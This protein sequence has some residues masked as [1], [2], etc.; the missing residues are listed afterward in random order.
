MTTRYDPVRRQLNF[1]DLSPTDSGYDD[2]DR[3]RKERERH[4]KERRD[5]K[6]EGKERSRDGGDPLTDLNWARPSRSEYKKYDAD[7]HRGSRTERSHRESREGSYSHASRRDS[8]VD[9][10]RASKDSDLYDRRRSSTWSTADTM[11]EDHARRA[12]SGSAYIGR[13]S[14]DDLKRPDDIFK[15]GSKLTRD[16]LKR[17]DK[18]AADKPVF[19]KPEADDADTDHD[20]GRSTSADADA[21]PTEQEEKGGEKKV[22]RR[23]Y[24]QHL[25]N[26]IE[27]LQQEVSDRQTQ[28]DEPEP[29]ISTSTAPTESG[30][31]STSNSTPTEETD[32]SSDEDRDKRLREKA[33]RGSGVKLAPVLSDCLSI[34]PVGPVQNSEPVSR[35]DKGSLGKVVCVTP[36]R[37]VDLPD[38]TYSDAIPETFRVWAAGSLERSELVDDVTNEIR[39][40]MQGKTSGRQVSAVVVDSGCCSVRNGALLGDPLRAVVGGVSYDTAR[41]VFAEVF[42]RGWRD[43]LVWAFAIIGVELLE[44]IEDVSHESISLAYRRKCL[45]AHP[46][47]G[48]NNQAYFKLQIAIDIIRAACEKLP[49]EGPVRPTI[50]DATLREEFKRT[51]DEVQKSDWGL[52]RLNQFNRAFDDYILRLMRFKSELLD[53]ISQLH[54]QSAYAILGVDAEATDSEIRKAYMTAARDAHPDKGGDKQTFQD[55]NNAYEKIMLQRKQSTKM[56]FEPEPT[57]APDKPSKAKK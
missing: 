18:P 53:S 46:N 27:S 13:P 21:K 31:G 34:V 14:R 19:T 56:D 45:M 48:G 28:L 24:L 40:W 7:A 12:E 44:E 9:L 15:L 17:S 52:E 5:P 23:A 30:Q 8:D 35:R 32:Q 16:D 39:R 22:R 25:L 43:A 3:L 47:R 57:V 11:P 49:E 55:I 37:K 2:V 41:A 38:L 42:G 50:D 10:G 36:A 4:E 33:R 26:T 54:E 20:S 29:K 1:D 51:A 6:R